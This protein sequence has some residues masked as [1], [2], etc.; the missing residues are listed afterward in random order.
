MKEMSVNVYIRALVVVIVG[1]F[2]AFALALFLA[3]GTF[4]WIAGWLF[5][6]LFFGFVII[7]SIWLLK[8]DPSL[9]QERLTGLRRVDQSAGE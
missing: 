6:I 7:I 3:A 2:L 9:L 5:L 1:S 8:H 4:R